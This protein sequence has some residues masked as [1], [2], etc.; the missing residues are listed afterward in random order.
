[1]F[2]GPG[3]PVAAAYVNLTLE[4]L[5]DQ[6]DLA[7][8]TLVFSGVAGPAASEKHITEVLRNY[9]LLGKAAGGEFAHA[10]VVKAAARGATATALVGFTG[11]GCAR[12]LGLPRLLHPFL[13]DI[14]TN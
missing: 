9:R 3:G 10:K 8:E 1:L 13:D 5:V 11:Y 4:A 12:S 7:G 14:A 6:G 2:L